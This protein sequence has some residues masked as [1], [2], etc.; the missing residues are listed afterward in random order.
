MM[1]VVLVQD[2]FV[3]MNIVQVVGLNLDQILMAMQQGM[4]LVMLF[5]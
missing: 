1:V 3:F 2:M 4:N 5:L